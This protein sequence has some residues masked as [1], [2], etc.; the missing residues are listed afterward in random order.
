MTHNRQESL[1]YHRT[2][3][4]EEQRYEL[5]STQEAQRYQEICFARKV[6]TLRKNCG[7]S[8]KAFAQMIGIS[9]SYLAKI[10]SGRNVPGLSF[11][12]ITTLAKGLSVPVNHLFTI[13]S[14]E[15]QAAKTFYE[16]RRLRQQQG[17]PN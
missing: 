17:K 9:Q 16:R 11:D 15:L 6:A 7:I 5:I 10:E 13:H 1:H 8:Q 14:D 4:P 12:I 3:V 2:A